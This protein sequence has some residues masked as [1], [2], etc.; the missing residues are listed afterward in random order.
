MSNGLELIGLDGSNPLAFL[1]A[2]GTLRTLSIVWPD[3]RVRLGWRAAGVWRPMLHLDGEPSADQVIEALDRQLRDA[4]GQRAFKLADDLKVM[5]PMFRRIATEAAGVAR[6][7]DRR[8]ADFLAAF[9]CDATCTD[10]GMIQDTALRTMSGAGHQHF[11]TFMLQLAA[12]TEPDHLR[13]ALLQ[14]WEYADP[15]P[16]MR[17]DPADDRRYALRWDEPSGDPIRT[18]RGANR[19]AIEGLPLLPTAPVGSEL[20]TTGFAGRGSRDTFWT[21]PIWEPPLSIDPIRS[22]LALSSLQEQAVPRDDLLAMGVTEVFRAQ[23]LT[24][25]K[26]RNFAPARPAESRAAE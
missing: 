22:L 7:E 15:G 24:I 9:G 6:P 5:G 26:Y 21:W 2:L 23:R 10:G 18:V 17:W 1:A 13:A 3:R 4:D 20:K 12:E 25:G 14:P 19:L 8:W 16:S 11:L